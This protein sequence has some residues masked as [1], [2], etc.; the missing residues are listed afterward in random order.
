MIGTKDELVTYN[1]LKY[2]MKETGSGKTIKYNNELEKKSTIV[3]L[4]VKRKNE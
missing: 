4:L 2:M 1:D 3:L